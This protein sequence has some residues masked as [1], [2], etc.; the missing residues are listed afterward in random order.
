M[1]LICSAHPHARAHHPCLLA[2]AAM[3]QQRHALYAPNAPYAPYVPYVPSLC[4]LQPLHPDPR[5]C[6]PKSHCAIPPTCHQAVMLSSPLLSS[7]APRCC[8][9]WLLPAGQA[10][11]LPLY[12]WTLLCHVHTAGST[13]ASLPHASLFAPLFAPK[14]LVFCA[15]PDSRAPCV[16]RGQSSCTAQPPKSC[17]A[18]SGCSERYICKYIRSTERLSVLAMV[19]WADRRQTGI[20]TAPPA[21]ACVKGRCLERLDPPLPAVVP[22][23]ASQGRIRKGLAGV[24]VAGGGGQGGSAH[25]FQHIHQTP[26]QTAVFRPG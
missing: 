2:S 16:H 3:L 11:L 6:C 23:F 10:A 20:C 17:A 13:A 26:P 1:Q 14:C 21:P 9:C 19:C 24:V 7:S 22:T 12:I 5:L 4:H 8:R 18:P 25:A 15:R